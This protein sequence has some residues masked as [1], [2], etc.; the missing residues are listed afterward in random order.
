VAIVAARDHRGINLRSPDGVL[1]APSPSARDVGRELDPVRPPGRHGSRSVAESSTL[2]GPLAG[3]GAGP[4]PRARPCRAPLAGMGT[5]PWPRLDPV[6]PPWP[7]WEPVRGRG[8][9]PPGP[10]G[11]GWSWAVA[12]GTLVA[13]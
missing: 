7:A 13:R 3:M 2:S 1:R 4:W 6:G 11:R 10:P 12:S 8:S 5:G 9:T